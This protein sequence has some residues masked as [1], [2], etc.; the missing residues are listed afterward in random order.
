MAKLVDDLPGRSPNLRLS[1]HKAND[2]YMLLISW[3][4]WST[5][6]STSEFAWR[7]TLI[8]YIWKLWSF[9]PFQSDCFR[10][11]WWPQNPRPFL[12]DLTS[13]PP[14]Y[15]PPPITCYFLAPLP[16]ALGLPSLR[17]FDSN[18][19][20]T[21][22]RNSDLMTLLLQVAVITHHKRNKN[23]LWGCCWA[24]MPC[25]A[26]TESISHSAT[27]LSSKLTDSHEAMLIAVT[28]CND[29]ATTYSVLSWAYT[30]R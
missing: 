27:L 16:K 25:S 4:C 30:L 12:L 28:C 18:C 3:H 23:M 17:L 9:I 1:V 29:C 14:S 6:W 15:P 7:M 8:E 19:Q 26:P 20:F 5:C 11:H 2:G 21:A 22:G 10:Y 24:I 13:T